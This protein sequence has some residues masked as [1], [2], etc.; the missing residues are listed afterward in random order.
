[1]NEAPAVHS[2][3]SGRQSNG[4]AQDASQFERSVASLKD[5]IQGLAAGIRENEHRPTVMTS[6]L[7]RPG[8]P[9]GIKVGGERAFVLELPKALGRGTF[10]GGCD[11]QDGGWVT[12]LVAP[13]ERKLPA[14]PQRLQ[15]ITG[16]FWH[17][18]RT[19]NSV[20]TGNLTHHDENC[21]QRTRP[22]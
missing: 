4:D 3:E 6:D 20:R 1:M 8:C 14:V 22:S 5:P 11:D 15:E 16:V 13:V 12:R 18:A 19:R 17:G 10:R 21:K 7:H 2:P 9:R